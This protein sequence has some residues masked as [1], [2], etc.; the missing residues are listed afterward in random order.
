MTAPVDSATTGKQ[1][2]L[3]AKSLASGGTLRY[4][5]VM[6]FV[7]DTTTGIGIPPLVN[8][9]QFEANSTLGFGL[10]SIGW[11]QPFIAG[12]TVADFFTRA[13][14]SPLADT[15]AGN[16]HN[17]TVYPDNAGSAAVVYG[18]VKHSG[19]SFVV[20]FAVDGS[21]QAVRFGFTAISAD[22]ESTSVAALTAPSA[23]ALSTGQL[24]G[25]AQT[26]ITGAS[27]VVSIS[28]QVSSGLLVVP[29]KSSTANTNYP[30]LVKGLLQTDV[31][32]TVQITQLRDAGTIIGSAG[33]TLVVNVGTTSA[34]CSFTFKL[35]PARDRKPTNTGINYVTRTYL[36]K[37]NDGT[38]APLVVADL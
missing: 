5:P 31:M 29:G 27:S 15:D 33:G 17:L 10:S 34:G 30:N 25:F 6:N 21:Q 4:I 14:L 24:L 23:G 9:A 16:Y 28:G 32:G 13:I 8:N 1:G 26:S 12:L 19:M 22:P 36:L 7:P 38:T 35:V 20:P 3:C 11:E 37:S 2:A 18:A